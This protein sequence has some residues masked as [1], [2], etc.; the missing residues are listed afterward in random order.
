MLI[1]E[2]R[3]HLGGII[4]AQGSADV[5]GALLTLQL[6]QEQLPELAARLSN[7]V[8]AQLEALGAE[9][10]VLEKRIIA[11]RREDEVSRRLATIPGIAP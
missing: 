10:E 8:A 3:G 1:H 5:K 4:A 7:G 9:I 11:R 6:Q 2:L